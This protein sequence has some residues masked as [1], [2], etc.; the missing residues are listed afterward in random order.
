MKTV[1]IQPSFQ[2]VIA[3]VHAGFVASD[4]F[5]VNFIAKDQLEDGEAHEEVITVSKSGEEIVFKNSDGVRFT[6]VDAHAYT[7]AYRGMEYSLR[8]PKQKIDTGVKDPTS[9]DISPDESTFMLGKGDGSIAIGSL[10]DG[11]KGEIFEGAHLSTVTRS[12]FFPSGRVALTTGL[13]FQIKIWNVK[14]GSC[15]RT[16][17]DQNQRITDLAMIERGRNFLSSSLDG[18]IKLW[19]CGSG[20][21][22]TT[23]KRNHSV[24]DGVTALCVTE[25]TTKMTAAKSTYEF[26]TLGKTVFAGHESGVITAFDLGSR[27]ESFNIPSLHS[28]VLSMGKISESTFIV[29]Y[30]KG[31]VGQWDLRNLKKVI[32]T[33]ETGNLNSMTVNGSI[34]L[35]YGTGY[36]STLSK[37]LN[38]LYSCAGTE[39]GCTLISSRKHTYLGGSNGLIYQF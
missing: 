33:Y 10:T 19:D 25:G 30:E 12:L 27:E 21:A 38:P 1:S 9:L 6:E 13:D 34:S 39:D 22:I 5:W 4:S 35:S 28:S 29:S 26:G 2:E 7:V 31:I 15:P 37:F 20:I 16:F 36:V 18:T 8:T 14:D 17:A 3:D 23:L 32:N 11:S 24:K